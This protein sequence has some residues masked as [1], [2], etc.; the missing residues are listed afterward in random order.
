MELL[1]LNQIPPKKTPKYPSSELISSNHEGRGGTATK[2]TK[3]QTSPSPTDPT[4]LQQE[5]SHPKVPLEKSPRSS[6]LPLFQEYMDI[7]RPC[8]SHQQGPSW[9]HP[10]RAGTT[11]CSSST[12]LALLPPKFRCKLRRAARPMQGKEAA[13]IWGPK[14]ISVSACHPCAAGTVPPHPSTAVSWF[15][16]TAVIGS[17]HFKSVLVCASSTR[18]KAARS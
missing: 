9:H 14:A 16:K 7:S 8:I 3:P 11:T 15:R 10:L 13:G 17:I 6:F 1:L 4:F 5:I 2:Q 18:G 12:G